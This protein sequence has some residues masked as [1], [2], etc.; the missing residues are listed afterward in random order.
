[1]EDMEHKE[2]KEGKGKRGRI[3]EAQRELRVLKRLKDNWD[4]SETFYSKE[5][6]KIRL[7]DMTDRGE[8]WRAIESLGATFPK[9]QILPDTNFVSY[10]KANL[11][12]SIYSVV[13]SAEVLPTSEEDKELVAAINIALDAI[14][15]TQDVGYYQFQAGERAALCNLGITQVGWDE[16]MI[17]GSGEHIVKGNV[18]YKNI[19]P[20]KFR[21]DP[22]A[23]DFQEAAWCCTYEDYH[24][25]VI[26]NN[27]LYKDKFKAY[28]Q[29]NE[30]GK[31]EPV[32]MSPDGISKSGAKGYYTLFIWHIR[33]PDGKISEIHTV[34]N[35]CILFEKEDIKP[36]KFPYA[37][38]YCNL[39]AGALIGT[40]EPAK[41]FANN[42]AYNMMDSIALTAEYK[43]QRPPKF[44]SDQS[45]LNVQAFA[46]YGDEADKTFVVAGP[47]DQAVHYHQFPQPSNFLTTLK[48]SLEMGIQ[49]VTG[50]DGRYTGRDTGS[51][52]TTGGTEE[53]LSRVT[54]VDNPK[55][56]MYERYCRDLT[57]LT[58]LNLI[59]YCPKRKFFRKKMD[60]TEYQTV[61]VDFPKLDSE[62]LFNYRIAI[63]SDLPKNKQRIA[64]MATSLLEKQYQ[65]RQQGGDS[66]NWI[67]E[68]EW[69]MFQDLPFKELML[70]R[71][72][73]Q[74]RENALEQTAQVLYQ[75]ANL[76]DNGA[77]P[78]DAMLA[79]AETLRQVRS[80]IVPETPMGAN[81]QLQ[82]KMSTNL[83]KS[84][85][86]AAV[87]GGA[88]MPPLV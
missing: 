21:R 1:M 87:G 24:K 27:P 83:G 49:T 7:L 50:V 51:I 68:E 29:K 25:S 60:S 54:L 80:G 43:N 32:L 17:G 77:T 12:A 64:A 4:I 81:P 45:K 86:M 57:E 11:L 74:R 62:T 88:Q 35:E 70:E 46:K 71:M 53:M 75:Y 79:A 28:L 14:W 63:S 36:R 41:I 9:Y 2:E 76:I 16:N 23:V 52:I 5:F 69:L 66:V 6:K 30:H 47:A 59:E 58:L 85:T 61:E 26:L 73:V 19:D 42:I 48:Q 13:K 10:I 3:S 56:I 8:L 22:Y 20:L 37:L 31:T 44:I 65:Y 55:I 40:S 15:D 33:R 34:N 72:G 39:P 82:Q 38:C 78:D 18:R 67:T 84:N